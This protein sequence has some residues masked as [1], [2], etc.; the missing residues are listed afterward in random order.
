MAGDIECGKQNRN[1]KLSASNP[2]AEERLSAVVA[3][4][5]KGLND[6]TRQ[7]MDGISEICL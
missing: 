1:L 5:Q 4:H 6:V 2:V 7:L 3:A